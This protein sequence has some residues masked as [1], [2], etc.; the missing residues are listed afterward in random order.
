M[1]QVKFGTN[2]QLYSK[3]FILLRNLIPN[4]KNILHTADIDSIVLQC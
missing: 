1:K 3:N 4:L 2:Y